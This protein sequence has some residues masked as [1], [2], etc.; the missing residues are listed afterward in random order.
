ML[1]DGS[2]SDLRSLKSRQWTWQLS[3]FAAFMCSCHETEENGQGKA[4]SHING[5]RPSGPACLAGDQLSV[6]DAT[7]QK[8]CIQVR[9]S[10]EAPFSPFAQLLDAAFS[11]I[12]KWSEDQ[13]VIRRLLRSEA[14]AFRRVPIIG[15]QNA[16]RA[17]CV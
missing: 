4:R 11:G 14:T 12:P 8:L 10:P 15:M 7:A 9:N 2:S 6:L 5:I 3:G 13:N 17:G 1:T 16:I